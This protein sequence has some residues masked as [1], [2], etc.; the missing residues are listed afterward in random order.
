MKI[1]FSLNLF[2]YT[3]ELNGH[4][5]LKNL[6][7]L[8]YKKETGFYS[9]WIKL[10]QQFTIA[11]LPT[12][13]TWSSFITPPMVQ[14]HADKN[15]SEAFPVSPLQMGIEEVLQSSST[16]SKDYWIFHQ[17]KWRLQW[18]M[19]EEAPKTSED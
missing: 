5:L 16:S 6:I 9:I 19:E 14:N 8:L 11:K 13:L 15:Q 3:F 10:D 4:F 18:N 7:M 2:I 12:M 17:C 1:I